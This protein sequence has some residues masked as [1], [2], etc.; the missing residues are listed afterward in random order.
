MHLLDLSG[1]L[2][3]THSLPQPRNLCARYWRRWSPEIGG[4]PDIAEY[5]R[6]RLSPAI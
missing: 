1:S 6:A 3:K 5:F 4:Y 2:R